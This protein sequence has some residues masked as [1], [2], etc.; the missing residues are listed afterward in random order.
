ML[1]DS[2]IKTIKCQFAIIVIEPSIAKAISCTL[3][4]LL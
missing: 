4:V 1:F 2:M 3:P